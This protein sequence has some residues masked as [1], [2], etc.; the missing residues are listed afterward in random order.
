MDVYRPQADAK[1]L[2]GQFSG[3]ISIGRKQFEV[4]VS[5][6]SHAV[7]SRVASTMSFTN[8]SSYPHDI[9]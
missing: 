5:N 3:S 7:E 6:G 9:T 4:L 8:A 1:F 2:P